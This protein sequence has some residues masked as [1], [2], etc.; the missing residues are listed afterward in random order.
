M[1]SD[2][3]AEERVGPPSARESTSV[4]WPIAYLA[5]LIFLGTAL[6]DGS[7]LDF[8]PT[9]IW[10]ILGTF[11]LINQVRQ[12]RRRRAGSADEMGPG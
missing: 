5:A 10:C 7:P 4:T 6:A 12:R 11:G 2:D 3:R 1:S 9:A 8:A